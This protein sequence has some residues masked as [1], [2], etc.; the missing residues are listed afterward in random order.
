MKTTK[1]YTQ[2]EYQ[3]QLENEKIFVNGCI[4]AILYAVGLGI[5]W[6]GLL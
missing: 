5:L 3:N 2:T 1:Y 6:M 4:A